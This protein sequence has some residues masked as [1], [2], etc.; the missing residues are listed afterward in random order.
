MY[1]ISLNTCVLRYRQSIHR[2]NRQE[3]K[4]S[5]GTFNYKG[6]DPTLTFVQTQETRDYIREQPQVSS[7]SKRLYNIIDLNC[8][9]V[10]CQHLINQINKS[11]RM[12]L[13]YE[14]YAWSM[15]MNMPTMH[16]YHTLHPE[17]I[18]RASRPCGNQCNH[19]WFWPVRDC[20]ASELI[21]LLPS[22]IYVYFMY[23]LPGTDIS[24]SRVANHWNAGKLIMWS[25]EAGRP[26]L[27]S[28]R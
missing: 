11:K 13:F 22:L 7:F 9:N 23:T 17:R 12:S 15:I 19:L 16:A 10:L 27:N 14:H 1:H 21:F 3:Q 28:N 8:W 24:N 2:A 5:S 6:W 20:K 18:S 26:W 4:L 25:G